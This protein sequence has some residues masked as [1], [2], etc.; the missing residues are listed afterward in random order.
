MKCI[1]S[2]LTAQNSA[3]DFVQ[4]AKTNLCLITNIIGECFY[5]KRL[6][7]YINTVA[8]I[9]QG[10][11]ELKRNRDLIKCYLITHTVI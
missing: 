9:W 1:F 5:K 8:F 6:R 11:K 10:Q 2:C 3:G 7:Y 4:N